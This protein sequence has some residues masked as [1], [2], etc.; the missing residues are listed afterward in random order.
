MV[1]GGPILFVAEVE[2]FGPV[3]VTSRRKGIFSCRLTERHALEAA[4]KAVEAFADAHAAELDVHYDEIARAWPPLPPAP[5]VHTS[6][7]H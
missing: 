4:L 2:G 5:R 1:L 6:T 7:R 3:G